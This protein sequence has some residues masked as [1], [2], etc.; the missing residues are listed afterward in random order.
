MIILVGFFT[1]FTG[2]DV[3]NPG[4]GL[5]MVF[6]FMLAFSIAGLMSIEG[7]TPYS[8]F[9]QYW[10]VIVVGLLTFGFYLNYI[11]RTSN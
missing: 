10:I 3:A 5:F 4:A 11:R 1:F 7:I 8:F 2:Y 9:N 6:G